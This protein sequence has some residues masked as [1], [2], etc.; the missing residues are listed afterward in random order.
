MDGL[1]NNSPSAF[2]PQCAGPNNGSTY[3][4]C[5]QTMQ[6]IMT[7]HYFFPPLDIWPEDYG[8]Y[9]EKQS[10]H[11]IDILRKRFSRHRDFEKSKII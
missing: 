11:T 4:V 7:A 5:V 6:T 2:F 1:S 10:E 8:N 9:A 3:Q